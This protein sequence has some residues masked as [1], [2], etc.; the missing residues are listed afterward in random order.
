MAR[1]I[2]ARLRGQIA[3]YDVNQAELAV[4]CDVSQ[5]QFSKIIRG[6]R[7][8]TLDQ[9]VV[10]CEALAIDVGQ[11]ATEV[12]NFVYGRDFDR[13]SPVVYV[14]EESR[15]PEPWRR[16]ASDLDG[17]GAAALDRVQ[18]NNIVHADFG[19]VGSLDQ[20]DVDIKQPPATQRTAAKKGTRKADQAPH[21][22]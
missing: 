12:E 19:N 20:D 9:F 11:L 18:R 7:P 22:E 14:E 15:L 8:M 3:R 16:S 1:E 10:I 17:W 5:S 13:S 6:T 4:L 2:I 21:A